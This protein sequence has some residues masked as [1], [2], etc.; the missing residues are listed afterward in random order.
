M[1]P[2]KMIV[3]GLYSMGVRIIS[4]DNVCIKISTP[5]INE[6][7]K[8][9]VSDHDIPDSEYLAK[10]FKKQLNEAGYLKDRKVLFTERYETWTKEMYEES[11]R[12]AL[13]MFN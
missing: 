12:Q 2:R 11:F 1:N 3:I 7:L 13:N 8:D 10:Q 6:A 4:E 5:R 9:R